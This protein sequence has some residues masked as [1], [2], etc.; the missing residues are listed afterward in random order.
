M[1]ATLSPVAYKAIVAGNGGL[2]DVGLVEV[3]RLP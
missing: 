1:V 3:Y 2:T